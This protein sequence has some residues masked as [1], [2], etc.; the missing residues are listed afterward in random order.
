M[1]SDSICAILISSLSL[2][3]E[4][5]DLSSKLQL[6]ITNNIVPILCHLNLFQ[7][8]NLLTDLLDPD[9]KLTVLIIS[10]L[11]GIIQIANILG[12]RF[13]L[14]LSILQIS[15]Q[16]LILLV[17]RA[18]SELQSSLQIDQL[19]DLNLH[20]L[21]SI[22]LLSLVL[23]GLSNLLSKLLNSFIEVFNLS[24][25]LVFQFL[26]GFDSLTLFDGLL[27]ESL[28]LTTQQNNPCIEIID[29]LF[30]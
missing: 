8:I 18:N 15:H 24:L 17:Q 13:I 25:V 20:T 28:R 11:E 5:I 27:M 1:L 14:L 9:S 16:P 10:A 23:I 30:G 12:Q 4:L 3:I 29:L 22:S 26:K 19:G 7:Y 6:H 21:N 2:L